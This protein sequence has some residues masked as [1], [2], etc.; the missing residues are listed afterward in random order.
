MMGP[1]FDILHVWASC[2]V[3]ISRKSTPLPLLNPS[4]SMYKKKMLIT[5][6]TKRLTIRANPSP[7][8]ET[9]NGCLPGR[10][11]AF[12]LKWMLG[13]LMHHCY[14]RLMRQ[15]LVILELLLFPLRH[16]CGLVGEALAQN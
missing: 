8:T 11:L 10:R 16:Y 5:V 13:L 7:P 2:L 14:H 15:E 4:W 9:K 6:D 12:W 3:W 1:R